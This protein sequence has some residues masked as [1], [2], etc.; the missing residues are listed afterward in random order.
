MR[1]I[2]VA[3]VALALVLG[4]AATA[5][6]NGS[7]RPTQE[8]GSPQDPID[9]NYDNTPLLQVVS[10]IGALTGRNFEVAQSLATDK[11][12]IISHHK[13]APEL[14]YEILE[15]ILKSKGYS[16][17]EVLDGNLVRIVKKAGAAQIDADKLEIYNNTREAHMGF[18]NYAIHLVQLQYVPADQASEI[19]KKVGSPAADVTVFQN[20]NMLLIIDSADGVRNMFEVI[21]TIDIPGYDVEF[22]IFRLE[23]T[24]AEALADQLSQVLLGESS[25]GA[26]RVNQQQQRAVVQPRNTRTAAVPGQRP[27]TI[28]GSA[29]ETLRLVPDERLNS[30]IVI[31]STSMM[32]QVRE[33]IL[34]LDTPTPNDSNNIHYVALMHSSAESVATALEGVSNTAPREGSQ[35]ANDGEVQPFE[36]KVTISVYE[37]N[38]ALLIIASPQDFVVLQVLI[39]QLDTP[40]RQVNVEAIIMEVV[41]SDSFQLTVEGA[42]LDQEHWFGLSNVVDLANVL[43][44]GPSALAGPGGSFGIIDGTTEV[45]LPGDTSPTTIQ[46]VPFLMRALET[47]TDVEILSRPNLLMKDNTEGSLTVGEDIPI[48]TSQSDINPSSGFTSRNSLA[49]RDVGIKLVVTPHINEGDYVTMEIEVESSSAVESSVG[50]DV[51]TTG[52]TIS[53]RLVK[54]EIVVKDGQTGIIGGLIRE[55]QNRS[56]AQIPWLGDLP[57]VGNLF[58]G[59][60]HGR[61]KQNL[62]VLVT[63]NIL[64]RERDMVEI[65]QERVDDFYSYNLDFLFEEGFINKVKAKHKGRFVD[66]PSDVFNQEKN[67]GV[68]FNAHPESEAHKVLSE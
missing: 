53:Q 46:N 8:L 67:G 45:M 33:L 62:V 66:R 25:G 12:T 52:A 20:T 17:I 40:R 41:L 36:K 4:S 49:R 13:V 43:V 50:I 10:S 2:V 35:T 51:N 18:D 64:D 19:I 57:L 30:L 59:R 5:Q 26:P 61:D 55:S 39:A 14:A 7:N 6:E 65:T 21:E 58:K 32:E 28:V 24:R 29:E 3:G 31:A 22:E 15:S 16:M 68:L 47:I 11:V 60:R 1:T 37:D 23:H 34:K 9:L 38:N 27:T 56:I 42:G 63:P 48:P 44:S 54:S